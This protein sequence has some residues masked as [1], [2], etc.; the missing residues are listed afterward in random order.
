MLWYPTVYNVVLLPTVV[1]RF[2]GISGPPIPL[3]VILGCISLLAS[4]GFSNVCIYVFTRNL[5]GAPWLASSS[6]AKQE[7]EIFV[8]RTTVNE[9]GPASGG[10]NGGRQERANHSNLSTLGAIKFS[11]HDSGF[12]SGGDVD[13]D[14]GAKAKGVEEEELPPSPTSKV[15]MSSQVTAS[16]I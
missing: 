7:V 13:S 10:D 14:V 12:C 3:P 5:G 9:A 1:C 4:M 11:R 8:E 16:E 6:L 2:K 15:C